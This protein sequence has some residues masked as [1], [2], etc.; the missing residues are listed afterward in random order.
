MQEIAAGNSSETR[1]YSITDYRP[2]SGT[3][4][5]RVIEVDVAGKLTQGNSIVANFET[6]LSMTVYPG[7]SSGTF[8]VS[9][10]SKSQKQVLLVVRDIQGKEFY[11]KVILLRSVNEIV[12]IEPEGKLAQGMYTV[13]A[14]S[15][16]AIYEKKIMITK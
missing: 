14:S 10:D 8:N 4:F 2:Y 3:S 7:S 13:I 11:S 5:Y 6:E 9:I 12:A 1:K 15:S 16:N